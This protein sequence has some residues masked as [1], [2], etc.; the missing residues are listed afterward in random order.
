MLCVVY[1]DVSEWVWMCVCGMFG[2]RTLRCRHSIA[3][4]SC[5][6]RRS[7]IWPNGRETE[8]LVHNLREERVIFKDRV[9]LRWVWYGWPVYLVQHTCGT[10]LGERQRFDFQ[11]CV[12]GRCQC[13]CGCVVCVVCDSR[14]TSYRV[15][16]F[17]VWCDCGE[18]RYSKSILVQ[19]A[20]CIYLYFAFLIFV[21]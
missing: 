16:V 15:H 2:N 20:H 18:H 14:I 10:Y 9:E 17:S 4:G 13:Q 7:W 3:I 21:C 6:R 11:S 5:R 12:C 1:L 8:R 19:Q